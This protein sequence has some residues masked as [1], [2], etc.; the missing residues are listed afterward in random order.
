[1]RNVSIL[2]WL[3]HQLDRKDCNTEI[4]ALVDEC[5]RFLGEEE[6]EE[7]KIE[8]E[9]K[10][11]TVARQPKLETRECCNTS[12]NNT[13]TKRPYDFSGG[14]KNTYCSR[15]CGAQARERERRSNKAWKI[16]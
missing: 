5:I 11:P 2:R 6:Q 4:E 14:L 15:S 12:C 7:I 8:P 13:I 1:M 10:R 9:P 3:D 16:T